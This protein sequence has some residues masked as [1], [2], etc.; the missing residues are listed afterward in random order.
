MNRN[1]Q[2]EKLL[3]IIKRVMR[4]GWKG[5]GVGDEKRNEG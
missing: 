3:L 1:L 5:P 2:K 4:E